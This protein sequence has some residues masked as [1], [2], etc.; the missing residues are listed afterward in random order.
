MA[1]KN[2]RKNKSN[3]NNGTV[4][5]NF[6]KLDVNVEIDYDKLAT[7]IVKAQCQAEQQQ[8]DSIKNVVKLHRSG[9]SLLYKLMSWVGYAV[10]VLLL[11][12]LIVYLFRTNW[13]PWQNIVNN[14]TTG[15]SFIGLIFATGLISFI[16]GRSSKEV[17]EIHDRNLLVSLTSSLVGFLALV[18]AVVAIFLK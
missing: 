12:S 10:S 1:R 9:L 8:E 2:R 17:S 6:D 15:V 18:V 3:A 4:V 11:I 16:L 13:A 7:A 14:V 5:N